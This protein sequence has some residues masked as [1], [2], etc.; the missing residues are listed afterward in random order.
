MTVGVAKKNFY[1]SLRFKLI[2]GGIITVLIP[3]VFTG[4]ISMSKTSK[5]LTTL[6][7]MQVQDVAKDLAIMTKNIIES[8]FVKVK[9]LAEKKL[10]VDAVTSQNRGEN[11]DLSNI[12]DN[13]QKTVQSMGTNYEGIFVTDSKG[14]IFAGSIEGGKKE[15]KH[16]SGINIAERDYFKKTISSGEASIGAAIRSRATNDVISIVCTPVRSSTNTIEGTFCIIIRI[17]YFS[18]LISNRKVGTTGYGYMVNKEGLVIAHPVEKHILNLNANALKGMELFA[19]KLI[20]GESG[21]SDYVFQGIHKIA[22]Y[23]PV[24][25][26]DWYIATTQNAEEF[27]SPVNS[28]RNLSILIGLAAVVITIIIFFFMAD[29]MLKPINHAVEGLKGI[30]T[31]EGDLTMRL[32]VTSSDEIG[33]LAAWF[34]IFMEKLQNIIRQIAVNSKQVGNSSTELSSISFKL[35]SGAE[36]TAKRANNVAVAAEEMSTNINNVA[37]AME[38]SSTNTN[39]VASASEEMTSTINEIAQNAEKARSVSHDAV[40][41]SKNAFNRMSE[42]GKAAQSIGKVTETIKEISDQTK[43]LSLNATIEAAR[44]GE[45]GKGFAVVANEIKELSNQTALATL[46]I[47]NQIDSVQNMTELNV[48]EIDQIANV[49]NGVNEIVSSIAAA[50]EEQSSATSEISN[51]ITQVSHGINDV[52]ENISQSSSVAQ[53][54][55]REIV[56][57]NGAAREI[58]NNSIQVKSSATDLNAMAKE[59]NAIVSKF[60]V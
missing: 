4:F 1:N 19:Q 56:Q 15:G 25:V 23:A 2:S 52:N 55:A 8:E 5:A 34:N 21:F 28:I 35:S 13:L 45:A 9:I 26:N 53:E 31:G 11:P 29:A 44:A 30:A 27:I 14:N 16:Y 57:V 24:G 49:I 7:E 22:G 36:E 3:L 54:I 42:L 50:V 10:V 39:M 33:E 20:S 17:S 18:H 40:E 41:K 47:K 6:S 32:N 46:D 51:N 37:A 38:Q 58:S 59:L 60:K 12:N 48:K 43:L